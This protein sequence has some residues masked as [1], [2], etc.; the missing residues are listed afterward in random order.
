MVLKR[1]QA[2]SAS[3]APRMGVRYAVPSNS[4][5]CADANAGE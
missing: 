4:V 5:S 2:A 1:P 3:H